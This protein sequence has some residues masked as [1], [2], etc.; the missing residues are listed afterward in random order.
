MQQDVVIN[1]EIQ[2]S[3]AEPSTSHVTTMND[4]IQQGSTM[5]T[6]GATVSTNLVS[7]ISEDSRP[8]VVLRPRVKRNVSLSAIGVSA[9]TSEKRARSEPAPCSWSWSQGQ[10]EDQTGEICPHRIWS[11]RVHAL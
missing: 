7:D 5:V 4:A 8:R 1:A 10:A 9:S 2:W 3:A 6:T 11:E